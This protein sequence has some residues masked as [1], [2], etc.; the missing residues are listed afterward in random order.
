MG[1][2]LSDIELSN[3]DLSGVDLS[4]ADLSRSLLINVDL[5]GANLRGAN[6]TGARLENVRLAGANLCDANLSDVD[7]SRTELTGAYLTGAEIS[8]ATGYGVIL[9]ETW[10]LEN[11]E[12]RERLISE[13]MIAAPGSASSV[14]HWETVECSFCGV[15]ESIASGA[16]GFYCRSCQCTRPVTRP[17]ASLASS[18]QRPVQPAPVPSASSV[19]HWET[20]E[21]SFCGVAESIASGAS[22]FYCRS[23]QCTRPVTRPTARPTKQSGWSGT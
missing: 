15:A 10:D 20:V 18:I 16:S 7:F 23:C 8:G 21:C 2:P 19:P 9:E 12:Y 6:L 1:V 17:T 3:A 13:G 14:P 11:D 5:S 22:G 4:G